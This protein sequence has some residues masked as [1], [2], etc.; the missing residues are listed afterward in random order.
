MPLYQRWTI[1]LKRGNN[2][3]YAMLISI[4]S[5]STHTCPYLLSGSL[6]LSAYIIVYLHVCELPPTTWRWKVRMHDGCWLLT[7]IKILG[8]I[9]NIFKVV[10]QIVVI[11]IYNNEILYIQNYLIKI[12]PLSLM[13]FKKK[14]EIKFKYIIFIFLPLTLFYMWREIVEKNIFSSYHL[15]W[16]YL[17]KITIHIHLLM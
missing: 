15:F 7:C 9:K 8:I 6:A 2:R 11:N 10:F 14:Y 13:L 12:S 4:L 17:F 1:V 16:L 5:F 3:E